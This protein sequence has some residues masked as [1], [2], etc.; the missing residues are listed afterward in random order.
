MK[1]IEFIERVFA[2]SLAE[3]N[4]RANLIEK[5]CTVI[6]EVPCIVERRGCISSRVEEVSFPNVNEVKRKSNASVFLA[7]VSS[8]PWQCADS[9]T[10]GIGEIC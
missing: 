2:Q 5:I 7:S 10:N 3:D 1:E 4:L 6:E 9:Q 8:G